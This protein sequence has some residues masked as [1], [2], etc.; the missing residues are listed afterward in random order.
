VRTGNVYRL[1]DETGLPMAELSLRYILSNP[2]IH[3]VIP[4]AQNP[5]EVDANYQ[6]ALKGALPSDILDA[7]G[8]IQQETS[9]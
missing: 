7:I 9:E 1:S 5:A 2:A 6:A 4:G 3:S 8:T